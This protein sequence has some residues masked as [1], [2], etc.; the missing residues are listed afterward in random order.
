MTTVHGK[1]FSKPNKEYVST[2]VFENVKEELN[3]ELDSTFVENLLKI[4]SETYS[5]NERPRNL[6]VDEYVNIL[7]NIVVEKCLEKVKTTAK[8]IDYKNISQRVAEEREYAFSK[9]PTIVTETANQQQQQQQKSYDELASQVYQQVSQHQ[10][11][12]QTDYKEGSQGSQGSED[13]QGLQGLQANPRVDQINQLIVTLD[14]RKDLIDIDNNSYCLK[15]QKETLINKIAL[16]KFMIELCDT[17]VSEPYIFIDIENI[18]DDEK[19]CMVEEKKVIGRMIQHS[20]TICNKT[21]YVYEPEDCI[22]Q[23]KKPLKTNH[24]Y[25]SFYNYKGQKLNLKKINPKKIIKLENTELNQ[26]LTNGINAVK[27]GDKINV[28]N[29][30][31]K[32]WNCT[33]LTVKEFKNNSIICTMLP[34]LEEKCKIVL[35]KIHLN[36]NISLAIFYK[37]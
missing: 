25:F 31:K 36:S 13:L 7:N 32:Y 10:Q 26:I 35:E 5:N 1:F 4:M 29:K 15:L 8:N 28:T 20:T 19:S 27:I 24:L 12:S 37:N 9:T 6:N 16:K 33:Q 22:I 21:M 34:P 23:L 3:V 2:A 17:V 11:E 30:N 14:F 18:N